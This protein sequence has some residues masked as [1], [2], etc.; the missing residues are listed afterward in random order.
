MLFLLCWVKSGKLSCGRL[1]EVEGL[2]K[3]I[4]LFRLCISSDGRKVT[5]WGEISLNVG[6]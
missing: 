6:K 2:L 5:A 3:S 1:D 4:D